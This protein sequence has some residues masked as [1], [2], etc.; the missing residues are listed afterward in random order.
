MSHLRTSLNAKHSG[1]QELIFCSS[2]RSLF[3][4]TVIMRTVDSNLLLIIGQL[5]LT[6][7]FHLPSFS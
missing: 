7:H 5:E 4:T 6:S 3:A 1:I 2:W